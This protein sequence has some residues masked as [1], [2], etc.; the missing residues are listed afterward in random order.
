MLVAP[1]AELD[2]DYEFANFVSEYRKSYFSIQEYQLRKEAFAKS[3]EEAAYM[4]ANEVGS[5]E[6]GINS[7]ADLTDEE[8]LQRLGKAPGRGATR[9]ERPSPIDVSDVEMP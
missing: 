8:F 4:N 2:I 1:S 3:L 9:N 6:Y 7:L 5:A